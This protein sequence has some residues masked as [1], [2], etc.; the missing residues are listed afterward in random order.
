MVLGY[1]EERRE[2]RQPIEKRKEAAK[3]IGWMETK[4]CKAL[5]SVSGGSGGMVAGHDW[6]RRRW[7]RG[8]WL[9]ERDRGG[10]RLRVLK[11]KRGQQAGTRSSAFTRV[12]QTNCSPIT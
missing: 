3:K 1:G 8:R 6:S 12:N 7:E 9:H 5:S 4:V 2:S 11:T 10:W